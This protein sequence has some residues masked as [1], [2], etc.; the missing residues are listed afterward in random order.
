MYSC[1][2]A[3]NSCRLGTD[4][5]TTP[6]RMTVM[7]SATAL[8]TPKSWLTRSGLSPMS[9]LLRAGLRV[10]LASAELVSQNLM[11]RLF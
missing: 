10:W 2:G 9:S 6:A 4:S 3:V 5:T 11:P 7:S 8:M 1:S